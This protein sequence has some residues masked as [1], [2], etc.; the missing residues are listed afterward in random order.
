MIDLVDKWTWLTCASCKVICIYKNTRRNWHNGRNVI[1]IKSVDIDIKTIGWP[2]WLRYI[3]VKFDDMIES[4][5]PSNWLVN[6][7]CKIWLGWC[8]MQIGS[9]LKD[10]TE[11]VQNE[12]DSNK[13]ITL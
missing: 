4:T 1:W 5:L 8:P 12:I 2:H 9:R 3:L 10:Q 6:N 13:I 7:W 11:L